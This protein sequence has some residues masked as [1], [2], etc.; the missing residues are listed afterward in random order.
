M[1][2]G[3]TWDITS[4][5]LTFD[6]IELGNTLLSVAGDYRVKLK[7]EYE[8]RYVNIDVLSE[9]A[10]GYPPRTHRYLQLYWIS[11]MMKE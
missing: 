5:F 6:F 8:S 10:R 9:K 7:N 2:Y 11:T 3:N 4:H 1:A